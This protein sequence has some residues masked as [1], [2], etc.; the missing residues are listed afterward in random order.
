MR[1][2]GEARCTAQRRSGPRRRGGP[3]R[4]DSD[5]TDD[6]NDTAS[7]HAG[8]DGDPGTTTFRPPESY[9]NDSSRR[10]SCGCAPGCG[11]LLVRLQVRQA[12]LGHRILG[13]PPRGPVRARRR[14]HRC[15]PR[16]PLPGAQRVRSGLYRARATR[17]VRL[18]QLVRP[19]LSRPHLSRPHLSRPHLSRPHPTLLHLAVA[20]GAGVPLIGPLRTPTRCRRVAGATPIRLGPSL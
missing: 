17:R 16:A 18:L 2:A 15:E 14:S 5:A 12:L 1:C 19:H 11:A 20:G 7:S 3:N 6:R 4:R 10:P 8:D 13:V 9:K